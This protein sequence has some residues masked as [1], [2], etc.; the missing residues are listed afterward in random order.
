M[1]ESE[2][3]K[4]LASVINRYSRENLSNTPD[5]IL[6]RYIENCL[7]AYEAATN[8]RDAWY[9]IAPEPGKGKE[10]T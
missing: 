10:A 2:L 1:S 8:E 6:A 3:V 7:H 9:G 4:E 5:F